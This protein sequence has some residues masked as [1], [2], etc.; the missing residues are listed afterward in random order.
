MTSK[1]DCP[2]CRFTDSD[3]LIHEDELSYAVVSRRPIN[4]YHVLVIPKDHFIDFTDLPEDVA[5]RIFITAQS[6]SAAVRKV[7][8]P[9]AISTTSFT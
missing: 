9:D 6:I 8:Q 2:F 7:C 3:V 5:T 4:R 1:D